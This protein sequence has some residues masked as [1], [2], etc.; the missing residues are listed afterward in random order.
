MS[1][2]DRCTYLLLVLVYHHVKYLLPS[3]PNRLIIRR[4]RD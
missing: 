4:M 2:L 1:K 3:I